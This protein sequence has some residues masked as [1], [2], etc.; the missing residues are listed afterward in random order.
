MS[1]ERAMGY[2]RLWSGHPTTSRLGVAARI[3]A[4]RRF[5]FYSKLEMA[6]RDG[7]V[8]KS[9]D[10]YEAVPLKQCG[11]VSADTGGRCRCYVRGHG[12]LCHRHKGNRPGVGGHH[13]ID[14]AS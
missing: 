1:P 13:V 8:R 2:Y 11:A 5:H 7:R 12:G 6:V 14:P 9:R 3:E 4:G 10:G